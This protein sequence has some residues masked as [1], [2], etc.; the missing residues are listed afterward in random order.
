MT[1]PSTIDTLRA[2]LPTDALASFDEMLARIMDAPHTIDRLY[3]AA[4]RRTVR[5]DIGLRND[6]G[7]ILLGEDAVRVALLR[8]AFH[9]LPAD[10]RDAEVAALYLFGDSDEK[11]FTWWKPKFSPTITCVQ[12]QQGCT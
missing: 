1:A 11:L 6:R 3:P 4:A 12:C 8:T 7:E 10:Q 2:A 5:G 9:A